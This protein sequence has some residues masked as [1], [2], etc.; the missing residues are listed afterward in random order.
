MKI[1][2]NDFG[3]R[4]VAF[5]FATESSEAAIY[6]KAIYEKAICEKTK[7]DGLNLRPND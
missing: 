7:G 3:R 4:G 1:E 5:V 2:A 6:E